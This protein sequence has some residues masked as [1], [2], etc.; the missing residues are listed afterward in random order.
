MLMSALLLFI[1]VGCA[2][3][4]EQKVRK[5]IKKNIGR[6]DEC[7]DRM[8]KFLDAYEEAI[9]LQEASEKMDH[10]G[11]DKMA[12]DS[13]GQGGDISQIDSPE[14]LKKE[15]DRVQAEAE[16]KYGPQREKL[17]EHLGKMNEQAMVVKDASR[18]YGQCTIKLEKDVFKWVKLKEVS[19]EMVSQELNKII[20]K[21]NPK[22][23]KRSEILKKKVLKLPSY[24]TTLFSNQ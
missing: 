4:P 2:A 11:F 1:I 18:T 9:R 21:R 7:L 24:N 19:T 13:G 22:L 8:E 6:V 16:Q 17:L 12:K 20:S 3:T 14:K 23:M 15:F 5:V 10:S